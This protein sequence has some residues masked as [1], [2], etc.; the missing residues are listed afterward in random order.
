MR[1]SRMQP[2]RGARTNQRHRAPRHHSHAADVHLSDH[3]VEN[4]V[5]ITGRV[6][7]GRGVTLGTGSV[8]G[9]HVTIGDATQLGALSFVPKHSVLAAHAV[10]LGIPAHAVELAGGH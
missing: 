6:R 8:I 2:R 3:T 5:V 4:G 9:I 10:Y 1:V 7:I